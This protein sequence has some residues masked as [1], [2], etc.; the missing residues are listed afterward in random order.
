MDKAVLEKLCKDIYKQF[1][2]VKGQSPV[3]TKQANDR[4]LVIFS[5]A[6]QTPDGKT[7]QQ[8]IRVIATEAGHIIK[9]S[10]SR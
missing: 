6:G 8:K 9:T 3:V 7:L 2:I 1:P 10:M 4:Y 5:A